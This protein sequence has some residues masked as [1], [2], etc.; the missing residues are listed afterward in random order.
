MELPCLE[1]LNTDQFTKLYLD[2]TKKIESKIKRFLREIK[3][4]LTSQ[5]YSRLYP[6][7]SCH[8]KFY[9]TAKIHKILPT[10]NV[11]KLPIRPIVSNINTSSY[12]LAKYLAKLLSPLS[13][14]Q[15]TVNS[16]KHLIKLIKH[17]EILTDYQMISFDVQSLSTSISL[18]K[19][20]E[21][22]LQRIYNRNEVT[23]EIPKKVMKE[24]LLLR[25]K[26]VHFSY[27]NGIYQ[28]N[29]GVAMG[30][31]LSPVLA[32]IF[33]E[34]PIPKVVPTLGR[35]LL[36]WKR[37]V[38]HRF[39]YE[40][41]A[42]MN[43]I[44]NKLN[45]FHQEVQFTYELEKNKKLAFLNVLLIRNKDTTETTFSRKPTNSDTYLSRNS[46]LLCSWKRGTMKTILRRAYLIC[47]TS[48]YLQEELDHIAYVFEKFNNY[49]KWVIKQLLEEVKYNH[50]ETSHEISQINE[51][52]NDEKSYLLLLPY[53]GPK[54][55][56]LIRSMKMALKSKLPDNI[57]NKSGYSAMRLKDKFKIKTVKEHQHDIKYYVECP[58]E[59]C[60]EIYV[61]ETGRRLLERVIDHND[62][63]KNFHIFRHSVETEH[64]LPSLQEFSIV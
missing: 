20:I 33:M 19:T 40:K 57:V 54:G 17:E 52:D 60:N 59:N 58:K 55:E 32:V 21:I 25:T 53:S 28:Q 36:K 5:K 24:L 44:L 35:S 3:T 45:G 51:V 11:D 29:D 50:H 23:T 48:D 31:P 42:T 39:C 34:E 56:K 61:A 8:G 7:G 18:D 2:P 22:I 9:G 16:A 46:F 15:C 38:D 49:P 4:N 30:S 47:L 27:S 41:I 1:L 26:E 64:R 37:Y 12:K 6:T 14:S 63:D 10:D 43:D 13:R 62:W